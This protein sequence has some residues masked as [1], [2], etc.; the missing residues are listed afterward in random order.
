MG[1]LP[2]F[3]VAGGR[4][5]LYAPSATQRSCTGTNIAPWVSLAAVEVLPLLWQNF[6]SS[7]YCDP[8][9]IN[10]RDR[11][12]VTPVTSRRGGRKEGRKGRREE[13]EREGERGKEGRKKGEKGEKGS[14]F[15][16][17]NPS[18]PAQFLIA[19]RTRRVRGPN[20]KPFVRYRRLY[21]MKSY[22]PAQQ[23]PPLERTQTRAHYDDVGLCCE[24]RGRGAP[25]H[26]QLEPL[27]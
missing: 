17:H 18:I 8:F 21:Y 12:V 13:G 9:S 25:T 11:V 26:L 14:R 7:G 16:V 1:L 24:G 27:D 10:S 20:S 5:T 15:Q 19:V 4:E 23:G 6:N 22:Q 3:L 2:P